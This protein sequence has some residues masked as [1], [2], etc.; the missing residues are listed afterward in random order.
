MWTLA[1]STSSQFQYIQDDLYAYTRLMI[2]S[3]ELESLQADCIQIGQVQ[4]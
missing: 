2:D 3:L 1:V 4:A